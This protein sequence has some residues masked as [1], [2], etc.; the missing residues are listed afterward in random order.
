MR[1]R[2]LDGSQRKAFP[3]GGV[4]QQEELSA[5]RAM[6]IRRSQ[7]SGCRDLSSAKI[8]FVDLQPEQ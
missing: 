5:V 4:P 1:I 8:D 7:P 6:S 2:S 3:F